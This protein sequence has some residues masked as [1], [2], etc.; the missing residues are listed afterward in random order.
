MAGTLGNLKPFKKGQSGNPGG[1]PKGIDDVRALARTKTELAINTLATICAKGK[2]ESARV[3]AGV[4]LLERGWGK[5]LQQVEVK[6]TPFDE[7]TPA[8]LTAIAEALENL[9]G[10]EGGASGGHQGSAVEGASGRVP[11]VQ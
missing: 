5:P 4:A 3:S 1:R 10:E 6:R 8:E 11:T 2:N 9:A 7:L